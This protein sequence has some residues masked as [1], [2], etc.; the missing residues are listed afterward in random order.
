MNESE[1]PSSSPPAREA[2]LVA[3]ALV[4]PAATRAAFLQAVCEPWARPLA[5]TGCW[6]ESVKTGAAWSR[7]PS[8]PS[9][10]GVASPSAYRWSN[11]LDPRSVAGLEAAAARHRCGVPAGFLSQRAGQEEQRGSCRA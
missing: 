4:Q 11:L 8:R 10:C 7:S 9:P 1:L 6:S 3:P 2:A 5:V